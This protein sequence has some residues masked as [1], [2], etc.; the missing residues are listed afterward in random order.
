MRTIAHRIQE[1]ITLPKMNTDR[2]LHVAKQI[3]SLP[4]A[5]FNERG[6]RD[7]IL[8]QL[9]PLTHVKVRVDNF[10]NILAVF[11]RGGGTPRWVLNAHMDHPAYV[12]GEFM[13]GGAQVG[14]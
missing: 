9:E 8:R 4:T 12:H 14:S 10:G 2:L 7:E 6:V 5:P 3:L 13:G 1:S 11:Q